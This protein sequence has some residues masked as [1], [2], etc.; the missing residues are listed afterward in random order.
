MQHRIQILI[1][2]YDDADWPEVCHVHD[3]ARPHELAGSCDPRAFIPLADDPEAE[4]LPEY[5]L[6][7]ACHGDRVVGFTGTKSDYIGWLY[8]DPDYFGNG[9]GRKLLRRAMKQAGPTAWTICLHGNQ[10]ALRLYL[11]ERF[12]QVEESQSDNAGYPCT[13]LRLVLTD[14]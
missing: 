10:R 12:K 3:R 6:L 11:S 9:I 2:A 4:E 5:A 7:V 13:C 8:V 1:R 14:R